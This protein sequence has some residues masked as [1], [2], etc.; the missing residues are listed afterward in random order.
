M[1]SADQLKKAILEI[2]E[3][4]STPS[5]LA[6]VYRV[7]QDPDSHLDDI[8]TLLKS[9]TGLISDIIRIANSP[10]FGPHTKHTQLESALRTIG[11]REVFRLVS[12]S[13]SQQ[14]FARNLTCY[15]IVAQ[16]YWSFSVLSGYLMEGLAKRLG[17]DPGDA[18]LTGIMH[19]TGRIVISQVMEKFHSSARWDGFQELP[20]WEKQTVGM[21]SA[22]AGAILLRQWRFPSPI[23]DAIENQFQAVPPQELRSLLGMLQFVIRIL[24]VRQLHAPIADPA[25]DD[26]FLRQVGLSLEEAH[27][28]IARSIENLLKLEASLHS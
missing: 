19:A 24:P 21:D 3:L 10:L 22:E 18:Y 27:A 5:V 14:F 8:S 20:A 1:N 23:C 15:R 12:I 16:D 4:S 26:P 9:D 7:L 28:L 2:E 17:K 25:V 6:K 13:L 11:L